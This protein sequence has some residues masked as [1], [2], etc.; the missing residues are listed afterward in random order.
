MVDGDRLR[1]INAGYLAKNETFPNNIIIA[2]N[3]EVYSSEQMFFTSTGSGGQGQLAFSNEFNSLVMIDGQHRF[4]S[5]YM[6]KK[7][8]RVIFATF[9][10]FKSESLDDRFMQMYK[11]YY[12]INKN[13]VKIDP[14]LSFL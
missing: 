9:L 3:P 6:G 10:F 14:N 4:F 11:M 8:D 12:E 1:K 2:L 5:L 7:T 13:K